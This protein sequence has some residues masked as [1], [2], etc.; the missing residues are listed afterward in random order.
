M[1]IAKYNKKGM[2]NGYD[3]KNKEREALDYY[4]TPTEEVENIL[5]MINIGEGTIL[6]PCAG[7]GHMLKGIYNIFPD[8]S[9]IATD[10]QDRA[11]EDFEIKTGKEYDFLSA[12]LLY[13]VSSKSNRI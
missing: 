7:G 6:E 11:C 3:K 12:D 9:V 10:I 2:Y 5:S 4:S 8:A 1:G 13:N